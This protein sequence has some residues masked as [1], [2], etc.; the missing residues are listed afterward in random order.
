MKT[1]FSKLDLQAAVE[2]L[3]DLQSRK[4][5]IVAPIGSLSM[6]E[7][8]H[9][10]IPV[11]TG[12]VALSINDVAK[13]QIADKMKIPKNY[14]DRM[15]SDLPGLAS[16]NFNAWAQKE[17]GDNPDKARRMYI[18][19]FMDDDKVLGT[20]RAFLSDR[21]L[22]F[23]NLSVL[24]MTLKSI[25]ESGIHIQ[26]DQMDL[27]DGNLYAKFSAPDIEIQAPDLLRNFR[28]PNNGRYGGTGMD[29]GIT[30]GFMIQNSEVGMKKLSVAPIVKI[31]AC[32][33]KMIFR[34]ETFD[35]RHLGAK[36][37]EVEMSERTKEINI[38]LIQSQIKD[39]LQT[40]VNPD[41][42][43]KRVEEIRAMRDRRVN[44][45][46]QVLAG[47][48]SP[49]FGYN[50]TEVEEIFNTFLG[51]NYSYNEAPNAWHIS[52]AMTSWAQ[53]QDPDTEVETEINATKVLALVDKFDRN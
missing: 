45:P 18:R 38:Q 15:M 34:D 52:Q 51:V 13:A 49:E 17:W 7:A 26:V 12:T 35:R 2:V 32:S 21:Y 23:D 24:A 39:A 46:E 36:M 10:V 31:M 41:F 19:A 28:D 53:N 43:G 9:F 5:D 16:L 37:E 42:L 4:L 22:T 48:N 29:N 25:Q 6:T 1:T 44:S 30:T 47:L 33:N 3:Q 8:G 11:N 40:F 50:R 27:T 14:F 20:M